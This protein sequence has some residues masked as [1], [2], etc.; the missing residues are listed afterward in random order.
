MLQFATRSCILHDH[1]EGPAGRVDK[2]VAHRADCPDGEMCNVTRGSY[3][4]HH[5][6][7]RK[8]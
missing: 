7:S 3:R 1:R 5:A 6:I 4:L 8:H 2:I